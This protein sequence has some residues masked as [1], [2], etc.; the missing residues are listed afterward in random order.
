MDFAYAFENS[1][2][3]FQKKNVISAGHLTY[4]CYNTTSV[5]LTHDFVDVESTSSDSENE[6][7]QL[8]IL[9]EEKK[10]K[11]AEAAGVWFL[12]DLKLYR[13]HT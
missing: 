6:L 12:W 2:N 4:Q 8:E 9:L 13:N 1:T 3:F 7:K 10:K 11:D 5:G